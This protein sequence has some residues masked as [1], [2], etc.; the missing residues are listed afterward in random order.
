MPI[1][2]QRIP[3]DDS[4]IP[5]ASE[6]GSF[7]LSK[8]LVTL[9]SEVTGAAEALRALRTHIMAQHL[10]K[11]RRALAICAPTAGVG[12]S[13][14]AANLAVG[15]SQI[16]VKTLLI[17][18]NLRHP[19]IDK[20][21]TPSSPVEGLQ[22][23]LAYGAGN[24]GDFME[25]EVL[26]DLSIMFAGGP[27]ENPQELLATAR[28]EDLMNFCLRDFQM[29]ILDTPPA[30]TCSDARRVSTVAGYSLIV[31]RRNKTLVSD[32]KTLVSQLESERAHV[33]G[34]VLTEG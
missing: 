21:F 5:S 10:E 1:S 32:V 27:T 15:L 25:S 16:G 3:V 9:T 23:C 34:T 31:S 22:Q 14:V 33:V 12:C 8:A 2:P 11:G 13:V 29:T 4:P 6:P 18:A 17:D 30:N 28:F 24:F 26:P 19:T 20:L 7:T